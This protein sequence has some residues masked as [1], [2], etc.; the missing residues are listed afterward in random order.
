MPA[1]APIRVLLVED[2][3]GDAR[4]I[5]ES[6]RGDPTPTLAGFDLRVVDRIAEVRPALAAAPADVLLLDLGLPDAQGLDS[7]RQLQSVAPGLPVIVLSGLSDQEVAIKAVREGAQDY[8]VKGRFDGDPLPRI[9]RFAVERRRADEALRRSE[10]R[11]RAA[12]EASP[13]AFAILQAVRDASGRIYAFTITDMNT[14]AE[15]LLGAPLD[16]LAGK[17][18]AEGCAFDPRHD[19]VATF[20]RVVESREFLEQEIATENA[21]TGVTNWTLRQVF[22]LGDGVAVFVRDITQR[23][24]MEDQLR[25]TQ[26]MEAIGQLAAGVAHDFRNLL[27]AI[28]GHVVNARGTLQRGHAALESL[29]QIQS[30]AAQ[31]SGIAGSLLRFSVKSS[32]EKK[33]VR[34]ASV[35]DQSVELLRASLPANI[36]IQTRVDAP[37]L[38]VNADA[39]QLQQV[40]MNLAINARD[41]MPAGGTLTVAS[42][43]GPNDGALRPG[44]LGIARLIVSDTGAGMNAETQA[45]IFEPYFTTKPRGQGTG[46]GLPIIHGIISDHGGTIGVESRT[47]A[48]STFTVLLPAISPPDRP[49][50]LPLDSTTSSRRTALLA[51]PNPFVREVVASMLASMDFDVVQAADAASALRL[52][53]AAIGPFDVL[54]AAAQLPDA[55]GVECIRQVREMTK[56]PDSR[57]IVIA[58]S[59]R[60]PASNG[61]RIAT[62]LHPFRRADLVREINKHSDGHE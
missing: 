23:H 36:T 7:F 32:T 50:R 38:Y 42:G 4:L 12:I 37:D 26:K 8:L 30:A 60:E 41:A 35:L 10:A 15:K 58:A 54:V 31:A 13:D 16:R 24:Q 3:P 61:D 19:S 2:N 62:L 49:E 29:A 21:A 52:A 28:Q 34:I 18:L 43:P 39:T 33:P 57:G 47:G 56:S 22:P 44:P 17:P 40:I 1:E 46:L 55:G 14:R 20:S 25:Q 6:L 59:G 5:E 51:D 48:G 9:V 45:R 27:S 53:R 11:F